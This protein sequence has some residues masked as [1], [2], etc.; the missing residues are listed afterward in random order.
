M[1]RVFYRGPKVMV[2]SDQFVSSFHAQTNSYNLR[3]LHDVYVVRPAAGTGTRLTSYALSAVAL[4]VAA[5]AIWRFSTAVG[6]L[7]V[8]MA[9]GAVGMTWIL[10]PRSRKRELRAT[11]QGRPVILFESEDEQTFGQVCRAVIRSMESG[12]F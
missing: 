11:Y 12:V 3:D 10:A 9:S 2:T 1:T 8:A 4:L 7:A 5:G 6:A